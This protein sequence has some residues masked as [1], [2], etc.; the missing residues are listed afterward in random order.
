MLIITKIISEMDYIVI[1]WGM[2]ILFWMDENEYK[3]NL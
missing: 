3:I 2:I 1:I